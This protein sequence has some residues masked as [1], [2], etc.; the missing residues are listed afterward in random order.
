[1]K[2]SRLLRLVL[3]GT[4]PFALTA[5]DEP[6]PA[7]VYGSVEECVKDGTLKPEECQ[8]EY[9]R[10]AEAHERVAPRYTSYQACVADFGADQCQAAPSGG[11]WFMPAMA[12]FMA[13]RL[14]DNRRDRDERYYGS[15]GFYTSQPLYRSRADRG[16][17]RT[18]ADVPVASRSGK[19]EVSRYDAKPPAKAVTVNR[20]GFG[21][22]AA[23]R[24]FWGG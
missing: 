13:A 8:T 18:A 17:W 5:C 19:V 9:A 11:G 7:V 10:A 24:G 2:R 15:S 22:Q 6:Q 1:M 4:A 14:L 21:S 23:A 16:H 3:M 20:G 12:G